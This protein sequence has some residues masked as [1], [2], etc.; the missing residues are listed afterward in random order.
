MVRVDGGGEIMKELRG[1][2]MMLCFAAI[3]I[4]GFI[5]VALLMY[6]EKKGWGWLLLVVLIIAGGTRM[7]TGD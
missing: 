6:Y 2:F 3:P 7:K 5:S 4:T 1:M